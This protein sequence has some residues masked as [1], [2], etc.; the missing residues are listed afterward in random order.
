MTLYTHLSHLS[1][2]SN[3]SLGVY[4]NRFVIFVTSAQGK[5]IIASLIIILIIPSCT[6]LFCYSS[7]SFAKASQLSSPI[8]FVLFFTNFFCSFLRQFLLVSSSAIPFGLFFS[9]S[10]VNPPILPY[11]DLSS[12]TTHAALHSNPNKHSSK[13]I[14]SP[15]TILA[16]SLKLSGTRKY[17]EST[18]KSWK[19][20]LEMFLKF[21]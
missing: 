6:L 18:N 11:R 20:A 16:F 7:S 1:H 13:P 2:H 10:I 12:I 14:L 3:I 15:F 21:W 5:R 17:S 8:P 4:I 19:M 9:N